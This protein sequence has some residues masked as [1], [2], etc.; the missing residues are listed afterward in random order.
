MQQ[1]ELLVQNKTSGDIYNITDSVT[2]ADWTTNR[3]DQPGKFTFEVLLSDGWQMEEGDVVRFSIDGE[4]QFYGW[5]FTRSEARWKVVS[6]T[7]YDRIRYLK[8]NASYTFYTQ[9]AGDIIK[10]IAG[11]L[12]LTTGTMEDTGYK[13]PSLVEQDKS[14]ID[15][16]QDALQQTLL[17]TGKVFVLYDDGEG[18]ALQEAANMVSDVVL[19]D[20]SLVTDYTYTTD[21]D[22]ETY[23]SIKLVKPNQETGR[24]EVYLTEDSANIGQWGLLQLY[25]KVDDE[26]NEAQIKAQGTAMLE[27]YNRVMRSLKVSSLGVP[28]LRAGQMVLIKSDEIGPGLS[29]YVLVEKASHHFEN[30]VHTMSLELF[31][32]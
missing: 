13:L 9:S 31:E 21:I 10:Q 30:G 26:Q 24:A 28:G 27:Y 18:L 7:C 19:G 14:C 15:I 22:K 6:V 23:N 25:Q 16:I 8:A 12:Q 17:N 11:D 2:S 5:I 4:M 3:C 1:Y 20:R 29:Q 32:L